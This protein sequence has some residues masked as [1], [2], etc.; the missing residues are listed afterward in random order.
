MITE[1]GIGNYYGC[2][3]TKEENGMYFWSVEDWDGEHWE[4]ITKELY[5]ALEKFSKY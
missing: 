4:E 1:H 5:I 3:K 2:L